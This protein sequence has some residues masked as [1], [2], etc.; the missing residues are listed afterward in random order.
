MDYKDKYIKY[1]NKYIN[2]KN[3]I[4]MFGG[5]IIYKLENDILIVNFKG[6]KK[7]MNETLDPISNEYE[8]NVMRNRE[9][10]N[11]PSAYIPVGHMLFEYK[12]KCKYVL[13]ILNQDSLPHELLHARFFLDEKYRTEQCDEW[14]SYKQ[15]TR[16][17][18][19]AF[20]KRL[21]YS[22]NVIIDEYQAYKNTEKANFFGFT[23]K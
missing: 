16:D 23:L 2:L 8:G 13:G 1:K 22:D 20:L 10:H 5:K 18:I 21:G 9:G 3:K 19:T 15:E 11:F 12:D 14:K 4:H 6:N 17:K 7:L